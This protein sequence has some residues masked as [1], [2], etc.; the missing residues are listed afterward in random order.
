MSRAFK[1]LVKKACVTEMGFCAHS[2]DA[3]MSPEALIASCYVYGGTTKTGVQELRKALDTGTPQLREARAFVAQ[4]YKLITE[5]RYASGVP[6][7]ISR[8]AAPSRDEARQELAE[9]GHNLWTAWAIALENARERHPEVFGLVADP[10]AWQHR[11]DTLKVQRAELFQKIAESFE[12]DDLAVSDIKPDGRA[13]VTM[14]LA[15]GRVPLGPLHTLGERLVN[16]LLREDPQQWAET[17]SEATKPST[18]RRSSRTS[19]NAMLG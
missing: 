7:D 8:M 13:L 19:S 16:H 12:S 3:R 14:A 9:V 15:P 1:D 18:S 17:K 5:G 11:L 10:I 6:R 4:I 2:A